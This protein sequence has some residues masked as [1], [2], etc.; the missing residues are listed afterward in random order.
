MVAQDAVHKMDGAG[1]LKLHVH[2]N[3]LHEPGYKDVEPESWRIPM[4]SQY[5]LRHFPSSSNSNLPI[6]ERKL[7][8][9][10]RYISIVI[11]GIFACITVESGHLWGYLD[12]P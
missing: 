1:F 8:L 9:R 10:C 12:S 6:Y 4:S 11:L 5:A 3:S 2:I 7:R